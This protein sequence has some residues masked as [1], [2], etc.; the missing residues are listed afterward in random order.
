VHLHWHFT[1][2]GTLCGDTDL[3]GNAGLVFA[4]T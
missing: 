3:P 1:T 2:A 4:G